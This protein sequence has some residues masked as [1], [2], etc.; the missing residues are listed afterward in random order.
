MVLAVELGHTSYGAPDTSIVATLP[1]SVDRDGG[2]RGIRDACHMLRGFGEGD[3]DEEKQQ[4]RT[5]AE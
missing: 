2:S 1:G 5:D 3:V 4:R